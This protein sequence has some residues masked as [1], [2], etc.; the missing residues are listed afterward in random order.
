MNMGI[1]DFSGD[2]RRAGQWWCLQQATWLIAASGLHVM[3]HVRALCNRLAVSQ[4]GAVAAEYAFLIVFI[5]IGA[6]IGMVLLGDDLQI[7]FE[8][9]GAALDNASTPTPDPFAT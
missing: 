2:N 3:D 6:A 9:L 5:S 7:Y 8:N 1:P 4:S